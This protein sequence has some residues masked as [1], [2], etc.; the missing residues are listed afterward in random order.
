MKNSKSTAKSKKSSAP[1]KNNDI[2]S[3]K[4]RFKYFS[5]RSLWGNSSLAGR[6][7]IILIALLI[8]LT[9]FTYGIAQYYVQKHADEP[10]KIGATFIPNYAEYFG[11][12]AKETLQASIDDLGIKRY[13][14]VTYWKDYEPEPDQYNFEK[15]DWQFDMIEKAGG[16]VALALGLR[17]PRWP[18]CHGPEW[19]MAKS[20]PDWTEDL[21]EF[22]GVVIDRYKDRDVLFEYQLENEFFL[23]VFGECPDFSRE[24][25]VDEF[26]YVK[27][28][29]P[30]RRV[31]VSRSNN[32]TPSW[33]IN[34]PR[35]DIVGASIYKRVYDKT[36]TK[37]YFEYPYP[38]WFYS[39]LAG[40]TE[41]TTGRNTMI[42]ELQTEAWLPEGMSMKTASLEELYETY[43]PDRV[44]SRIAYGVNTGIKTIDVWG[45]EWW[46]HMK[47]KR[48]APEIWD[49]TKT[50]LAKY[51]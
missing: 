15:L 44:E 30:S 40:A 45:I 5:G 3:G 25:L 35:A 43:G 28:K 49:N 22:M 42:H 47:T 31:M 14:L 27:A 18:E 46:Y 19:A 24:R 51:R 13:R 50:E 9:T 21:K 16:E 34:E 38:S 20:V 1:K 39:F 41:I 2:L 32:A 26:N 11:L 7:F 29:D 17:Q 4:S 48:G 6:I 37:R 8:L 23:S 33:P 10:L 36:V 12:D